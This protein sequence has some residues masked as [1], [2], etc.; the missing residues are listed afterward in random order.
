MW[1]GTIID[2][3]VVEARILTAVKKSEPDDMTQN[4]T[5]LYHFQS[6]SLD[7]QRSIILL[8]CKNC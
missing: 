7:E 2:I 4:Y 1:K 6:I 8:L 3:G 5:T